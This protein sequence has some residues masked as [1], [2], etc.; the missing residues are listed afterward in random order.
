MKNYIFNVHININK[1]K[2][3]KLTLFEGL[4]KLTFNVVLDLRSFTSQ[5]LM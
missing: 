5:S 4:N 3:P 2:I 1:I